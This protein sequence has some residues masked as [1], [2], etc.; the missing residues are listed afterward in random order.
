[1]DAARALFIELGYERTTVSDIVKRANVA[2]GTFYIYFTSKQ[3][4]L[5]AIIRELVEEIGTIIHALAARS[6]LPAI[7]AL[8]QV[9]SDCYERINQEPRLIE[10]VLLKANLSLPSELIEEY[11]PQLTPALTS[12]IE[13][14]VRE[15]SMKVT[16]PHL[17]ADLFWT[18]GYRF[19][20]SAAR[21]RLEHGMNSK[22]VLDLKEAYWEFAL[23]AIG[24][25][26]PKED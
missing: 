15:G 14:G 16:H 9:M 26:E 4:I 8:K 25:S 7:A 3:E 22:A 19:F 13:R 21:A 12:L 2:Q 5:G 6:D 17:A 1:M 20:E 24:V 10:A 23:Q 11:V 18:V